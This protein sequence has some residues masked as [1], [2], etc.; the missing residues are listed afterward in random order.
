MT[1]TY[2]YKTWAIYSET[3]K[4]VS[5]D[6]RLCIYEKENKAILEAAWLIKKYPNKSFSI[7]PLEIPSVEE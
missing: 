4:I 5:L 3:G 2:S 1:P 7:K 6:A